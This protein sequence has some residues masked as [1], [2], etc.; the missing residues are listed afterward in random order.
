[1]TTNPLTT[2]QQG[3]VANVN[4]GQWSGEAA[5]QYMNPYINNVLGNQIRKAEENY[6]RQT[7]GRNDQAIKTGMF[8]G[9][10]RAVAD[11]MARRDWNNQVNDM[12]GQGFANA[13]DSGMSAFGADR[14]ARLQADLANQQTQTGIG[15][16]NLQ[17]QLGVQQLG[18]Q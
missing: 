14:N 10:R 17:A 11:S 13:Y 3:P 18:A 5:N 2:F 16:R 15:E 1:M 7:I 6:Q 12:V 4:A 8:G 9:S